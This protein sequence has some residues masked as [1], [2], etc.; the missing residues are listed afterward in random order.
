MAPAQDLDDWKAGTRARLSHL[1]AAHIEE[2]EWRLGDQRVICL[3][4]H[5]LLQI[6]RPRTV[7]D[8]ASVQCATSS[9]ILSLFY[10]GQ[11]EDVSVFYSIIPNI[12]KLQSESVPP[13]VNQ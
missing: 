4:D 11:Q 9:G 13:K 7:Q 10:T 1:P 5:E 8:V 2:R 6:G 12:K 3:G